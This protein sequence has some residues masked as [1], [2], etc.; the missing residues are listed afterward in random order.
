MK[1][2]IVAGA[3]AGIIAGIVGVTY[4][5]TMYGYWPIDLSNPWWLMQIGINIVWGAI[6]GFMYQMFHDSIP[7]KGVVKGVVFGFLIWLVHAI[8]PFTFVMIFWA[9]DPS[10]TTFG[11]SM[12]VGG[13]IVRVIAYGIAIGY[14][15]KK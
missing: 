1:N 8:Y 5:I 6:F 3:V 13:F 11:N 7:G 15:F 12:V 9:E 14:L 10:V 2:G 4:I